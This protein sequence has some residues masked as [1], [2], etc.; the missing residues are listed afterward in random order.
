MSNT[1][2][3]GVSEYDIDISKILL[4]RYG[5][6]HSPSFKLQIKLLNIVKYKKMEQW[7]S[8]GLSKIL[9]FE[10]PEDLIK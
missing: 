4:I 6:R 2:D 10:V 9:D 7:I 1:A 3:H 8:E 5:N